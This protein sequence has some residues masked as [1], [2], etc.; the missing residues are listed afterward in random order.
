MMTWH[1]LAELRVGIPSSDG[2]D[3]CHTT[4]SRTDAG[5]EGPRVA[6]ERADGAT[7]GHAADLRHRAEAEVVLGDPLRGGPLASFSKAPQGSERGAMG[8][9]DPPLVSEPLLFSAQHGSKNPG[10]PLRPISPM[11]LLR[12]VLLT[13]GARHVADVTRAQTHHAIGNSL[14]DRM[15]HLM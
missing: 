10:L 2:N 9:R 4:K 15:R 8:S 1:A 11:P 12:W 13:H 14:R 7:A 6:A 3:S 5:D